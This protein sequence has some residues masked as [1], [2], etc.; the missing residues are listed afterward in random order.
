MPGNLLIDN[1]PAKKLTIYHHV[2]ITGMDTGS[3]T[4]SFKHDSLAIKRKILVSPG[5]TD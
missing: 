3:H 2:V 4:L 5:Q 1:V